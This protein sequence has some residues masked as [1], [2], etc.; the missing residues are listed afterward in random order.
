MYNA[1]PTQI[2]ALI[3]RVNAPTTIGDGSKDI[4]D[5][6]AQCYITIPSIIDLHHSYNTEPYIAETAADPMINDAGNTVRTISYIIN[7]TLR[8]RADDTGTYV[9]YWTRSPNHSYTKY[10]HS[11]SSDGSVDAY[12]NPNYSHGILIMISF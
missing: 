1:I 10:V 5:P 9:Q 12:E 11:I 6:P 3:K 2:K 4:S 8:R 7:N